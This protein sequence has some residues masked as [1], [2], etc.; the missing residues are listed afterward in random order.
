M[1]RINKEALKTRLRNNMMNRG[2]Y[3]RAQN[4][5]HHQRYTS[6]EVKAVKVIPNTIRKQSRNNRLI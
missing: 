5:S 3:T 4:R 1:L 2:I 6:E